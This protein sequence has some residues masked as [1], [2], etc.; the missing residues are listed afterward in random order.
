MRQ[1]ILRAVSK[2][3]VERVMRALVTLACEGNVAA[4]K[5]VLQ[6]AVG[7]PQSAAE[8]DR[9]DVDEWNVQ[10]D[11]VVSGNALEATISGLPIPIASALATA[12][13]EVKGPMLGKMMDDAEAE[14]EALKRED[15]EEIEWYRQKRA[16]EA[17]AAG[18]PSPASANG[19]ESEPLPSE[20]CPSNTDRNG[21]TSAVPP[22]VARPSSAE[23]NGH[24]P[25]SAAANGRAVEGSAPANARLRP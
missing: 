24:R 13:A 21:H 14:R 9:V 5:L 2:D 1:A 19:H 18:R 11:T 8:P 25:S 10:K 15:E 17:A 6:Y 22:S 20:A 4:A 16:R 3:D 7:K 23:R 12:L